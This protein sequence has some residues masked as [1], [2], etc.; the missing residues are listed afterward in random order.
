[1]RILEADTVD[2]RPG[3]RADHGIAR[4]IDLPQDPPWAARRPLAIGGTQR[5]REATAED[6][7]W[8]PCPRASTRTSDSPAISGLSSATR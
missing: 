8:N 2:Y 7:I 4:V 6:S 5:A 3:E 1:M